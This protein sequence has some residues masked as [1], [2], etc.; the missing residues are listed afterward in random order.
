MENEIIELE[1][2]VEEIETNESCG[3]KVVKTVVAAGITAVVVGVTYKFVVKPIAKK[4]GTI[5]K[6]KKNKGQVPDN[7]VDDDNS[8]IE[9]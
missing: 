5:L 6:N 4:V 8:S 1:T 3:S 9:D 2:E 7:T